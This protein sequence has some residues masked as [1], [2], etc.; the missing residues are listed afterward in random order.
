VVQ[1]TESNKP[2]AKCSVRCRAPG[3]QSSGTPA[4]IKQTQVFVIMI[5][6][7]YFYAQTGA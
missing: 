1:V 7:W 2:A 4:F 5:C 6:G 3:T